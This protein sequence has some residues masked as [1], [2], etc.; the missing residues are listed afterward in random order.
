MKSIRFISVATMVLGLSG[1]VTPPVVLAPVGPNPDGHFNNDRRG[2]LQVFTRMVEQNDDQNQGGDGTS[3][4]QQHTD[5]NIYDLHGKPVKHVAN[6]TGHYA[7]TPERIVLP[8]GRYLV[9]AEAKDHFWVKVPVTIDI[10][11]TTRVHLDDNWKPPGNAPK[12]D[13]V[14]MPSGSPVGWRASIGKTVGL[15]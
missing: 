15:Q 4:W 6:A 14:T 12:G 2:D 3:D 13:L 7:E 9:K 8:A 5:Y 11:R 1:C 10:G